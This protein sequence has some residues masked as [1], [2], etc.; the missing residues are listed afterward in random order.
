MWLCWLELGIKWFECGGYEARFELK[1]GHPNP[2]E[3]APL[4]VCLANWRFEQTKALSVGDG[5]SVSMLMTIK[6]WSVDEAPV[7]HSLPA[8]H[9]PASSRLQVRTCTGTDTVPT[10]A[11]CPS[12]NG[13]FQDKARWQAKTGRAGEAVASTGNQ[14]VLVLIL[15]RAITERPVCSPYLALIKVPASAHLAQAAVG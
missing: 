1:D 10:C 6:T 15:C 5:G 3:D 14:A 2:T 13:P 12:I 8:S 4:F 9:L 7:F 11:A